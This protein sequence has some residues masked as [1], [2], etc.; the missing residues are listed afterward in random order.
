MK[1]FLKLTIVGVFAIVATASVGPA[2]A[3]GPN[4]LQNAAEEA[5]K[6]ETARQVNRM[7]AGA[8][9]C[10]V[11]EV[12][13]VMRAR[14]DGRDVVM[15]DDSGEVIRDDEGNPVTDP[16]DLPPEYREAQA[17]APVT[18]PAAPGA[19]TNVN[20]NFSAGERIIFYEDYSA[21]TVGD[22]PRRLE[23]V[24]GNWEVVEWQGRRLL[25]NTGPRYAAFV[26]RLP[27]TLPERFTIETV[28]YFPQTNQRAAITME[29]K[30]INAGYK[31]RQFFQVAGTHGT[32]VVGHG[33]EMV[34]SMG[35]DP[36]VHQELVPVSIMV[37][38]NHV[39]VYVG[40]HRV[41]NAPNVTL[42][43]TDLLQF[44]NTYMASEKDP[45]YFGPIRIAAGGRDLYSALEADGRVAVHDILFDTDQTTI[46][47]ES[48]DTLA[49]ISAMMQEHSDLRLL[50]EGHT[51]GSGDFDHNM[52][53]S[54]G[55]AKAVKAWLVDSG[56][57]DAD[58][59][60][61]VGLGPTQPK[62]PNESDEGRRQNRRVELV[63]F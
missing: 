46:R 27:E 4:W 19:D 17:S 25:R 53:L 21:D 43:R 7:V 61:T 1:S 44:S 60:R 63:K 50:I 5:A 2:E 47:P 28:V 57:I 34:E 54:R 55:R 14:D 23:L 20:S 8:I 49:G 3:R 35:K 29:K 12:D 40:D 26:I 31:D 18:P 24:K 37:D 58:R 10:A 16:N 51:D 33:D 42:L 15:V 11:G 56:E 13:C 48:A 6:R 59:L 52:E 9:R 38:G 32:G 30:T 45:M 41:A 62:A 22:F 39:K 36:R